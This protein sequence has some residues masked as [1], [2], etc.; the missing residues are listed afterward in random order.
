LLSVKNLSMSFGGVRAVNGVSFEVKENSIVALIGPNGAG[1]STVLNLISGNLVPD[2]GEIW[3][4]GENLTNRSIQEI[5]RKGIGRSFQTPAV[6]PQ[7][8]TLENVLATLIPHHRQ[9]YSLFSNLPASID[10]EAR[11]LLE[12]FGIGSYSEEL[13]KNLAHG[14]KRRLELAM[15]LAI[16]PSLLLLDEPTQGMSMYETR[17]FISDIKEITSKRGVTTLLVEHDMSVVFS[18]SDRIIVLNR[19][20]LLASGNAQEVKANKAVRE[21]YLGNE[22]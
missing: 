12:Y 13:A 7:L 20:V 4:R 9:T 15:C 1:K 19:G 6:F 22:G 14:D 3:F 10:Q 17:Q 18:I 16:E 2:G 5:T 21:A 8:T 11:R